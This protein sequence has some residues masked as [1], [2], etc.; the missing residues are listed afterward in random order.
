MLQYWRA[1]NEHAALGS[2]KHTIKLLDDR[3]NSMNCLPTCHFAHSMDTLHVSRSKAAPPGLRGARALQRESTRDKLI[4]HGL[5]LVLER[6]WAGCGV[7][8]VLKTCGVPKGSFYHYF[9]SKD[10]FGYVVL[11]H[12]QA[13]FMARLERWFGPASG[14]DSLVG[15][16]DGF[17]AESG[18]GMA[19]HGFRRGCL[20]GA[21]GQEVAGLHDTFREHLLRAL[22]AWD[23]VLA[24]CL[25]R[26]GV[27]GDTL[28]LAH[29]FWA[30]W[31]GAVLRAMLARDTQPLHA[32]VQR[33]VDSL[34]FTQP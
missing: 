17:L 15:C 28:A 4:H 8:A 21:L 34:K 9:A 20:V 25:A 23:A 6:G 29:D 19:R 22:D 24:G 31:E 2:C 1:D 13:F 16:F 14:A 5:V 27:A 32:A 12:Y 11:A 7:D 30:H 26:Y 33:F 3:S 10:D 18:A